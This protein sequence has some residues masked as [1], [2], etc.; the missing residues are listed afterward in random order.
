M[1]WTGRYVRGG[2]GSP[3]QLF[4]FDEIVVIEGKYEVDRQ[5]C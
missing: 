4:S 1:K 5:V 3:Y 2:V